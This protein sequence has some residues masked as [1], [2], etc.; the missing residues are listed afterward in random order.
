MFCLGVSP[1]GMCCSEMGWLDGALPVS[2]ALGLHALNLSVF[3]FA[4]GNGVL[5][6]MRGMCII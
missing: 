3:V 1:A 4:G 5:N 6:S 2:S